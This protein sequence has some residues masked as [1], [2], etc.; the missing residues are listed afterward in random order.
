[1][2]GVNDENRKDG[3]NGVP[4]EAYKK[5]LDE[6]ARKIQASGSL[7][8]FM[9]PSM[10]NLN[11]DGTVGNMAEYAKAMREVAQAHN[12]CLV[13][14]YRAWELLPKRGYNYMVFL[15][16][17]INHPVDLGHDLMFRGLKAAFQ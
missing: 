15:G 17:C 7:V 4:P 1:M 5:N 8:V 12:A 3:G 16:N 9:T 13:D 11:W 10:K 14:N 6:I 2:L